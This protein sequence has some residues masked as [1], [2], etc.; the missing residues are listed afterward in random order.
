MGADAGDTDNDGHLDLLTTNFEGEGIAMFHNDGHGRFQDV[1]HRSELSRGTLNVVGF[2]AKMAD[3]DC[4]GLLDV[5]SVC[6]APAGNGESVLP[7]R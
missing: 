1:G 6:S 7:L 4:D 3:F 5:M 2:G